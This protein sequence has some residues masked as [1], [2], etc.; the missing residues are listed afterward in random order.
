MNP[1][2]DQGI[3]DRN[4]LLDPEATRS[5]WE[6]EF[7]SDLAAFLPLEAIEAVI[8]AGRYEL[9][10][11]PGVAYSA[12]CDPSGGRSDAATLA[13][14][15]RD[16]DRVI[17]DVARRWKAPHDPAQVVQEQ[18]ELLQSYNI[19]R[20]IGDRYAGAW[21]EQEF[22]KCGITYQASEK[23]RS[24][25]YLELLPMVLSGRVE[26]LDS[27]HLVVE[28]R[29]LE[30]RTRSG[31]RDSVDHTPRG[32]DDLANSVAGVCSLLGMRGEPG[33]LTYYKNLAQ[34]G[35]TADEGRANEHRVHLGKGG[36][37]VT[38]INRGGVPQGGEAK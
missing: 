36:L 13:I 4:T 3:I 33:I 11:L 18:A 5:E 23:D 22:S 27:K 38:V 34:A 6:V 16:H 15:H 30:R 9:S 37:T 32:T 29:S 10:P 2:I 25:L 7:R 1:T 31:G 35:R 17:L 12:F 8:A 19:H 20:I 26:L 21:P 28:L 24:T 14:G